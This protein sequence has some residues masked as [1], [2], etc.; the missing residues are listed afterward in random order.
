MPIMRLPSAELS[1]VAVLL[2][3][4]LSWM[5]LRPAFGIP[6]MVFGFCL[7]LW[8]TLGSLA[9]ADPASLA[10]QLGLLFWLL[11]NI[12][13]TNAEFIWDSHKPVG[14]LSHVKFI[15]DLDKG[16]YPRMM[17]LA[18]TIQCLTCLGL[19][20]FYIHFL[21]TGW[22]RQKSVSA[23]TDERLLEQKD[24]EPHVFLPYLPLCVYCELFTL[25]WVMMDTGWAFFNFEDVSGGD[26]SHRLV[27][28]AAGAGLLAVV[29]QLDCIRRQLA[30]S[31]REDAALSLAEL[32][33][34]LGN[35]VWMLEDSV[36]ENKLLFRF[37]VGLFSSGLISV[38]GGMMVALVDDGAVPDGS[39]E[40]ACEVDPEKG[41]NTPVLDNIRIA[42]GYCPPKY[43]VAP[44]CNVIADA[45]VAA[46]P[47]KKPK[48]HSERSR[49]VPRLTKNVQ[50]LPRA[51]GGGSSDF[52]QEAAAAA[53]TSLSEHEGSIAMIDL[54]RVSRQ[55]QIWR[56][57]CPSIRPYHLVRR[58][59]DK[60]LVQLMKNG[61]CAFDCASMSEV[62]L[63]LAVG[64]PP[65]DIT[66]S[67]PQK[68]Q[69]HLSQAN[70]VG[71]KKMRFEN[72]RELRKIKAAHPEAEL[73]LQIAAQRSAEGEAAGRMSRC[74]GAAA[75]F[76]RPLLGLAVEL[77]MNVVGVSLAGLHVSDGAQTVQACLEDVWRALELGAEL[78]L[79][80]DVLDLGS[81]TAPKAHIHTS[82]QK[83]ELF[84]SMLEDAL[85]ERRPDPFSA[86]EASRCCPKVITAE[87]GQLLTEGACSLL[88]KVVA[89][90][91]SAA[92]ATTDYVL[93][94]GLYGALGCLVGS[95]SEV[96]PPEKLLSN[97]TDAITYSPSRLLGPARDSFDIVMAQALVPALEIG[98]WLLW[99]NSEFRG[100]SKTQKKMAG[101]A[102][103][104]PGALSGDVLEGADDVAPQSGRGEVKLWYYAE[105]GESLS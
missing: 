59:S 54:G 56:E 7:Q 57:H 83:F 67:E 84:A 31:N 82:P 103:A 46:E 76:W 21:L 98:D 35:V 63:A 99:R 1:V 34:V 86:A 40:Q 90:D 16:W 87:T 22:R 77:G 73:L 14:F 12:I 93:S 81:I 58:Q 55:M 51:P 48:N 28:W 66:Y 68:L 52:V 80:L 3:H 18:L 89:K 85:S 72:E 49:K 10:S 15:C 6:A 97:P 27:F 94:D 61:G 60:K 79:S 8:L 91:S 24:A 71:V 37:A 70:K 36:F 78:G 64:V 30:A 25:P 19:V 23:A 42:E 88:T 43:V 9:S 44:P 95:T 104:P 100:A 62:Q 65:E 33:W 17:E 26:P 96:H 92:A 69:Q 105:A 101:A 41:L 32:C 47:I 38:F 39:A 45:V 4:D 102:A 11:G 5:T 74:G 53:L 29:M 50:F 75:E 20:L 2:V 13:W